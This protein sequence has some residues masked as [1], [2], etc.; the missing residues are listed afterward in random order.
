MVIEE[1]KEEKKEEPKKVDDFFKLI[2]A[3]EHEDLYQ[4]LN[5]MGYG[6]P[7]YKNKIELNMRLATLTPQKKERFIE[8]YN[9]KMAGGGL[10]DVF[11]FARRNSRKKKIRREKIDKA[12]GFKREGG[13]FINVPYLMSKKEK[14]IL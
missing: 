7:K 10:F 4:I 9:K 3:I 2:L 1:K 11:R 8:L 6:V 13:A 5:Q 14:N 12:L